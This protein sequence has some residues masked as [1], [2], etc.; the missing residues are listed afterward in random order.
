[1]GPGNKIVFIK[2]SVKFH[3]I[4]ETQ[5]T[6]TSSG[7]NLLE[8]GTAVCITEVKQIAQGQVG[9]VASWN[10]RLS[11]IPFFLVCT[12]AEKGFPGGS[13]GKESACNVG[14]SIPEL[15]RS[16]GEGNGH[17]LQYSCLENPMDR[18][19]M[20]PQGGKELDPTE[21]LTHCC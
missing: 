11:L 21:R 9:S 2:S 16:P 17:P 12:V 19:S 1:M 8:A 3:F 7:S 4:L 13:D 14:G 10:Q 18:G 20:S 6:E 15:G 5:S